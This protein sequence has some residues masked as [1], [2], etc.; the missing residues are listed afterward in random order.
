MCQGLALQQGGFG[1]VTAPSPPP[2][3]PAGAAQ[4]Q[5][6]TWEAKENLHPHLGFLQE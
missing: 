5:N 6:N 3:H 2:S 4:P 1:D